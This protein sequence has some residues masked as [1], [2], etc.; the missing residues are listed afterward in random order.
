MGTEETFG[1]LIKKLRL[2]NDMTL[3]ELAIITNLSASYIY[4]IESEERRNPSINALNSLK[5]A[6]KIDMSLI[7]KFFPYPDGQVDKLDK[8][9]QNAEYLF[10]NNTYIFG[11]KVAGTDVKI[12]LTQLIKAFELYSMKDNCNREDESNILQLVDNLKE[13]VTMAI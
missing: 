1:T 6:L 13:Q 5:Y 7:E 11:G 2:L 8:E 4:R 12:C 3:Q 10:L 9:I